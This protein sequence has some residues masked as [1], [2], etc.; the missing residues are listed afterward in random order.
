MNELEHKLEW[1]LKD[2]IKTAVRS[3]FR[4]E[5]KFGFSC[6]HLL[7]DILRIGVKGLASRWANDFT[8]DSHEYRLNDAGL[9]LYWRTY[10]RENKISIHIGGDQ[11]TNYP[12]FVAKFDQILAAH[13]LRTMLKG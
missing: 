11:K 8:G 6:S 2:I 13:S 4:D 5:N 9:K 1:F 12:L 10:P 3:E 7:D